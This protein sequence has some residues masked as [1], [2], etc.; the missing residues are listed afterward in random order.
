MRAIDGEIARLQAAIVALQDYRETIS[1]ASRLPA[2]LLL[3]IFK[4]VLPSHTV[5]IPCR[6]VEISS[7]DEE[8][9]TE[10][11]YHERYPSVPGTASIVLWRLPRWLSFSYVCHRWRQVAIDSPCLWARPQFSIPG[12]AWAMIERSKG[13][14]LTVEAILAD[15]GYQEGLTASRRVVQALHHALKQSSRVAHLSIVGSPRY[16]R[17][18]VERLPSPAPVLESLVIRARPMGHSPR[19]ASVLLT[20]AIFAIN[21]PQLRSL[22]VSNCAVNWDSPLFVQLRHLSLSAVPAAKRLTS[23]AM[24]VLL[25]S[26]PHLESAVLENVL[27]GTEVPH[28]DQTSS[29]PNL[30]IMKL[31]ARSAVCGRLLSSLNIPSTARIDLTCD[32]VQSTHASQAVFSVLC[33]WFK[34]PSASMVDHTAIMSTDIGFNLEVRRSPCSSDSDPRITVTFSFLDRDPVGHLVTASGVFLSELCLS[35]L[36]ISGGKWVTRARWQDFF[37]SLSTLRT[38][39]VIGRDGTRRLFLALLEAT[40][41]STGA[42]AVPNQR[43]MLPRLAE[44]V[45]QEADYSWFANV[46]RNLVARRSALGDDATIKHIRIINCRMVTAD[47][48]EQLSRMVEHVTWDHK[49]LLEERRIV[50]P[51]DDPDDIDQYVRSRTISSSAIDVLTFADLREQ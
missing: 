32:G 49:A 40:P 41:S 19:S 14:P 44:I 1:P 27:R 21:A 16:I 30:Q 4:L 20:G 18:L 29:L 33:R 26:M 37:M 34:N 11:E 8:D 43:A 46:L 17:D 10:D 45:I 9:S 6:T 3:D 47:T 12:L 22:E 36:T 39:R 5:N 13:C 24:A 51:N 50:Q 25:R 38:L 48:V 7:S 15:N 2:E 42:F 35:E 31:H 28:D 23:A